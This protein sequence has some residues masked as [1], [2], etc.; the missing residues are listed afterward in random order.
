M[1]ITWNLYPWCDGFHYHGRQA[2]RG[3][4]QPEEKQNVI[5]LDTQPPF[6]GFYFLLSLIT[7]K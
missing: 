6:V 7:L 1:T 4:P 3:N 5:L 2:T